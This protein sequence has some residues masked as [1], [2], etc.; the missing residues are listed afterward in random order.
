MTG[1]PGRA[2]SSGR[3]F[4]AVVEA[5]P[6]ARAYVRAVAGDWGVGVGEVEVV[7]SELASCAVRGAAG[8]VFR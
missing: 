7:A 2:G 6:A 8:G 4:P 3:C 5:V 1:W